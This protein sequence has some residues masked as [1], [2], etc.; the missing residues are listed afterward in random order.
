MP[1]TDYVLRR[2]PLW[3]RVL[4]FPVLW[5]H[6]YATYRRHVERV[7]AAWHSFQLARQVLK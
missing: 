6:H 3:R 4:R 2:R 7:P 5:R 1:Y